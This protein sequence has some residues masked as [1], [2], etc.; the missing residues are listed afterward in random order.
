MS[1]FI[2]PQNFQNLQ[3]RAF[4]VKICGKVKSSLK[5]R[6]VGIFEGSAQSRLSK[7]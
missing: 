4:F 3:K 5:A 6:N 7:L 1:F 2:F